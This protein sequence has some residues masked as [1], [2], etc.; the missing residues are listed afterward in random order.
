MKKAK[1][2]IIAL[3]LGIV[4]VFGAV[5]C[6]AG[7]QDELQSKIDALQSQI[8]EMEAQIGERD[9][10]IE[11]LNGRLAETEE[12]L[13]EHDERIEQL[14][15]ELAEKTE[16]ELYS[17]YVAYVNGWLT[18]SDI[19]SIAYYHNGGRTYNEEIM[20][21]EYEPLPKTPEVLSNLTELKI[22][23]TAAK[24]Y[25]EKFNIEDAVADGF[26]ITQYCGTYGD[27]IAVMMRDDYSGTAAVVRT[28]SVA[29]VKIY[30]NSGREIQIWR[31]T[32]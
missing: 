23:S 29:G 26:T 27:C 25:R 11:D 5:G 30:Y 18:K 20:S 13:R 2:V 15:K 14:E 22:K 17:L 24:D 8:A 9:K 31:K 12:Q 28:V 16:G 4:M 10:T 32:K 3:F 7:V 6:N 1:K 19:M 21:E